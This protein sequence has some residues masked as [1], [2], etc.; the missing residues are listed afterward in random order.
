MWLALWARIQGYVIAIGGVLIAIAAIFYK[1]KAAGEQ[2][3]ERKQKEADDE[4][5]KRMEAVKAATIDSTVD[6]LRDGTF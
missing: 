5:R 4:A 1:G 2:D 3:A 6:S